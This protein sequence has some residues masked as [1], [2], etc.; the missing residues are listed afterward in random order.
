MATHTYRAYN[1]RTGAALTPAIP[2]ILAAVA[3][4]GVETSTGSN[5]V[6]VA[7]TSGLYPGMGLNIPNLPRG[8]FI[9]AIKSSTI[10]EAYCPV[11]ATAT[12][13]WT[14]TAANANA[15]AS[16]SNMLGYALGFNPIAIPE[17]QADGATYRNSVPSSFTATD[18]KFGAAFL[19]TTLKGGVVPT[20]DATITEVGSSPYYLGVSALKPAVSD[21][22][23][24]TPP[25]PVGK[26]TSFYYLVA[27]EGMITRIPAGPNV[28][29]VRTA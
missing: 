25:R 26:W 27:S 2:G 14:V 6:T 5:L 24:G 3:L 20:E 17:P 21:A 16:A 10:I 4:T 11:Y 29:I 18:L 13:T 23:K 15:T 9:H 12:A 19:A 22:W 1:I 8:S 7:S 28:S